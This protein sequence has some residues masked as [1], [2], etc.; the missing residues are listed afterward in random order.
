[1][2]TADMLLQCCAPQLSPTSAQHKT[3]ARTQQQQHESVVNAW[4]KAWK[5]TYETDT[6]GTRGMCQMGWPST[7][8]ECEQHVVDQTPSNHLPSL[9]L[10]LLLYCFAHLVA[11]VG[12]EH[13][14]QG[15]GKG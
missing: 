15:Q 10:L 11:A 5:A 9:L 8:F 3:Q 1:M 13:Q 7:A 12:P 6:S 4:G 14:Q 2:V